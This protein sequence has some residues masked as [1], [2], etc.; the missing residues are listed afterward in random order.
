MSGF[1]SDAIPDSF[2][3]LHLVRWDAVKV[4]LVDHTCAG[5]HRDDTPGRIF[6][7]S[8][9]IVRHSFT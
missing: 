2:V 9:G 3:L 6:M 8:E 1:L 7:Q 5:Y 4:R